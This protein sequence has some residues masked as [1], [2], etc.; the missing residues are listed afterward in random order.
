MY[1]ISPDDA[2]MPF[3]EEGGRVWIE[4]LCLDSEI[5]KLTIANAF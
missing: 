2:Q 5:M 4:H 1:V 3:A